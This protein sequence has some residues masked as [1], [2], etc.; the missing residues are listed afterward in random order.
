MQS[1]PSKAVL[2]VDDSTFIRNRV[3]DAL[4]AGGYQVAQAGNGYQALEQLQN[5][6]LGQVPFCCIITDLVMPE[7]DGFRLLEKLKDQ[8][9]QVPVL[10][11]TADVQKTTRLRCEELGVSGFSNKPPVFEQLRAAV[12]RLTQAA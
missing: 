7:M 3:R 10:V 11:L 12:D 9:N 2:V 6:Q 8:N 5:A 1:A 4:L